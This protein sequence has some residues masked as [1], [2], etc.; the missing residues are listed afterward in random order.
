MLA[1]LK[2]LRQEDKA[3]QEIE[4]KLRAQLNRLKQEERVLRRQM[5]KTH[6]RSLSEDDQESVKEPEAHVDDEIINQEPLEDL[7]ER[8]TS[9]LQMCQAQ[10]MEEKI[11]TEEEEEEEDEIEEENAGDMDGGVEDEIGAEYKKLFKEMRAEV[12]YEDEF[13]DC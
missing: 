8:A 2:F 13:E 12:D 4:T 6:E 5:R 3:L 9:I 11:D 7:N 1:K 10:Y